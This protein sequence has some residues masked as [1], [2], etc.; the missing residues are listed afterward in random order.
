M[1]RTCYDLFVEITTFNHTI[2]SIRNSCILIFTIAKPESVEE[3][4]LD[5]R[6][7]T[8][9]VA[10]CLLDGCINHRVTALKFLTL[11][12]HYLCLQYP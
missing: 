12:L 5:L 2:I 7:R 9:M 3:T 6:G 4:V 10:R 8:A 1:T 11:F